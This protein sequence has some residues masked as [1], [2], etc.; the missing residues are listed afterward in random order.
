MKE[1]YDQLTHLLLVQGKTCICP[2]IKF[3]W[4]DVG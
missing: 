4:I 1:A 2:V 3:K